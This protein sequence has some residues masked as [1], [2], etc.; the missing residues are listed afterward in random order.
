MKR[1]G[2]N[3][4]V[5]VIPLLSLTGAGCTVEVWPQLR[6]AAISA[7]A[8]FVEQQTL[9]VLTEWFGQDATP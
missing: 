1:L 2:R 6:D 5:M 8:T 3:V 4:V 9:A 7:T